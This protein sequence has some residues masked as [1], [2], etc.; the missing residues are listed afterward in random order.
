M[1]ARK[2][3]ELKL[4]DVPFTDPLETI[5]RGSRLISSKVG[6]IKAIGHGIYRA[7]DPVTLSMG[8][9][10]PDLSRFSD[11]MNPSKAGGGGETVEMAM[12][13]TFGEAVE[14]Y[15]MLFY[16]KSEM[17][18]A[19]YREVK[20]DAVSPDLLR[21]YSREQVERRRKGG[22]R[23]SYF[24][25]D[26]KI[27]WVWGYSLTSQQPR[28]VP[29]SLVYMNYVFDEDEA[30]IGRN[31]SSGLA[32]GLTMEEA[33]LTGLYEVVERDAFAT[34][35]LHHKVGPRIVIDDPELQ[36]MQRDRYQS[37]HPSVDIKIF[38]ITLDI[39]IPTTFSF[40]R[41]PA[42]FGP[43]LCVS[44]VTRLN[45]K[46][47]IRKSLREIGQG[48]PYVRYLLPQ[49]KDWEPA[50]DHTDLTS[51][52]LHCMLYNKRP[53]LVP[54][55]LAFALDMKEEILLS[56]IED[57][58]TGR[59]KGDVERCIELLASSGHEVIV[60]DITTLDVHDLGFKVV[61]VMI[62]GLVPL[63]GNHNTPYLGVTRLHELPGRLKWAQTG[64]DAEAG[65]N[66]RPHPFP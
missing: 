43:A 34:C 11:I 14:R 5:R 27:Y 48:L 3:V 35:W 41:R 50:A 24:D 66:P 32:A 62:P 42:E 49:L 60:T 51:F 44:S 30:V 59:A 21:L 53:D 38:D 10:A 18:F 4:Q 64:W 54:D 2:P 6:L 47:L 7:Q 40:M 13:A 19:S 29:A 63:H 17:M 46:D 61:R 52:D 1:A 22:A 33:I 8:I 65:I 20:E 9:V 15:C 55:A 37:E 36:A 16:D 58:S 57:R 12:A 39:P 56:Q 28:L 23:H 26:S 31:A 25:D 45:T